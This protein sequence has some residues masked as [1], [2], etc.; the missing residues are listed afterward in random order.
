M[1]NYHI[2]RPLHQNAFSG[3]WMFNF[4]IFRTLHQ[5]VFSGYWMFNYH[6]LRPLCQNVFSGSWMFHCHILNH[7]ETGMFML[8]QVGNRTDIPPVPQDF[9]KCGNYIPSRSSLKLIGTGNLKTSLMYLPISTLVVIYFIH[10]T[11]YSLN[12]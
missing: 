11:L 5:N 8:L 1:F 12:Y 4:H 3:Y 9:P 2:L 7:Q 10:S 6:I